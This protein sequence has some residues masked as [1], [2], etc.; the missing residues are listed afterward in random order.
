MAIRGVYSKIEKKILENW[1]KEADTRVGWCKPRNDM[2]VFMV[3]DPEVTAE[4]L[5]RAAAENDPWNPFWNLKSY[6]AATRWGTPIGHPFFM[7]RFAP[8]TSMVPTQPGLFLTFYYIGYDYE[9]YQPVRPGDTIRAWQYRPTLEDSTDLGGKGPRKFR[10]IDGQGDFINQRDEIVGS[11]K[12]YV[13]VTLHEGA[14]P[15]EPYMQEYG[16]RVNELEY[17]TGLYENE[18]IQGDKIRYW[19]DIKTGD[20]IDAIT[21]GPTTYTGYGMLGGGPPT[22]PGQLPKRVMPRYAEQWMMPNN[23][24]HDRK[25]GLIYKTH[26]G[27]HFNDRA[28]QFEGG[29]RAWHFN[30][31][32]R[33]PMLRAV[34]NW[35]GDDA[36]VC[37]FGWRH[38]WRTPIGDALIINGKVDNK[39][40]EDDDHLVDIRC[41]C[42]DLRGVITDSARATVKLLTKAEKYPYVNK[43]IKR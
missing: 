41:W 28:A 25:T 4:A 22:P 18:K 37:K 7:E 2:P 43:F 35:M 13:E 9:Y 16:Y 14:P 3:S 33:L 20:D 5:T 1:N 26:G 12:L 29:P 15:V 34:T 8:M 40:I 36:F 17:L 38:M 30:T 19:D 21:T 6:A 11:M 27:R 24:F 42:L 31:V 39:Y 10:Y 23:Y 32:P